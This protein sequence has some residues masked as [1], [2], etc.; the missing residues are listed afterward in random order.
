MSKIIK[1]CLLSFV[2]LVLT[3]IM[4]ILIKD[5][6]SKYF[7][8]FRYESEV[9][10]EEEY[11]SDDVN[12]FDITSDLSDVIITKS[13]SNSVSVKVYGDKKDEATSSLKNGKLIINNDNSTTICLFYCLMNSKIE[14]NVP[15]AEYDNLK[16]KIASGDIDVKDL[17]F[18]DIKISSK[19]GDINIGKVTKADLDLVSGDINFREMNSGKL[20]TI[21]GNIE[22]NSVN[23]INARTISGDIRISS[24][25]K[26][27]ELSTT[28]GNILVSNLNVF[29]N[30]ALTTIS[31][32][33]VVNKSNNV[34]FDASTI[35]GDINIEENNRFSKVEVKLSTTSGNIN[36]SK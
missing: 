9:I 18:K 30:S 36:I 33:I 23:E 35:S 15:E 4:I 24:I 16:I 25:E 13:N 29:D 3:G 12:S 26:V 28:S 6:D 31:G 14:I 21:S 17:E 20:V 27:C 7:K 8:I 32:D 10:L 22:G 5:K 1:I 19:S 11:N 34:Y 2:A